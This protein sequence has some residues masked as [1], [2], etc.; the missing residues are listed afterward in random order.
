[1]SVLKSALVDEQAKTR[2][3]QKDS[4]C[5]DTKIRKLSSENESLVFRNDQLLKR[6][7]ILQENLDSNTAAFALAKGKKK[8]KEANL[9]LF[10]ESSRQAL[11]SGDTNP[12]ALVERE[13]QRSIEENSALHAKLFDIEQQ[14]EAIVNGFVLRIEE[15]ELQNANLNKINSSSVDSS[16]LNNSKLR[17]KNVESRQQDNNHIQN[18]GKPIQNSEI[19][20]SISKQLEEC[21][22]CHENVQLKERMAEMEFKQKSLITDFEQ[23]IEKLETENT[24]LNHMFAPLPAILS[25]IGTKITLSSSSIPST[26]SANENSVDEEIKLYEK[27]YRNKISHL[28]SSL[29]YA[30]GRATYFK[31]ECE[32][33]ITENLT[34]S[35]QKSE[36]QKR[37]VELEQKC[38]II[39]DSL[40]STK[41]NY[42]T[43]M[44][45]LYEHVAD[46]DAK[47][48]QSLCKEIGQDQDHHQGDLQNGDVKKSG[49]KISWFSSK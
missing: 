4:S 15:L 29:N 46:Q 44:R 25:P 42:E 30:V 31:Q 49:K 22:Y 7:E 12:S 23:K 27:H 6:V 16:T 40:E 43:Q 18:K 37:V 36:L 24:R 20:V 10:G 13:L 17:Y 11:T 3:L 8:H 21:K 1:V 14:N 45:G 5:R 47:L 48:V 26:S 33:L 2:E 34:H 9:R 39:N 19:T 41:S 38:D 28:S 35:N 32:A